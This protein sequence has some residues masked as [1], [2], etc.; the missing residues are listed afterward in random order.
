MT[1]HLVFSHGLDSSPDSTKI[2]TLKPLA[3]DYGWRCHAPDYRAAENPA[4]RVDQLLQLL[5]SLGGHVVLVGSSLGGYVS[6]A[7]SQTRPVQGLFLIAPAVYYPGYEDVDYRAN[8]AG[9]IGVVHGWQDETCPVDGSIRFARE[10]SARLTLITGDHILH[11]QM[12]EICHE[13]TVW[14]A[15]CDRMADSAAGRSERDVV[16]GRAG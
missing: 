7:A 10:H 3:E 2:R 1:R 8:C 11:E 4:E 14:L 15:A 16:G 13:F 5:G 9:P 6:V 12:G